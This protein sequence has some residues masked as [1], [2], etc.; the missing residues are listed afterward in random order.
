MLHSVCSYFVNKWFIFYLRV[1]PDAT[2]FH[3]E[4]EVIYRAIRV[5]KIHACIELAW[6]SCELHKILTNA[7]AEA[8]WEGGIVKGSNQYSEVQWQEAD[9]SHGKLW[10]LFRWISC[11]ML[12]FLLHQLVVL[13]HHHYKEPAGLLLLCH[14]LMWGGKMLLYQ[15]IKCFYSKVPWY[16]PGHSFLW[17]HVMFLKV[18]ELVV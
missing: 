7:L 5:Y 18:F 12:A 17:Q 15:G 13:K 14:M 11:A 10:S 4:W 2:L 9:Q 6:S 16:L 1:L 3:W 8:F